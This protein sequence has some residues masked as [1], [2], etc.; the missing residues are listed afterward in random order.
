MEI[1]LEYLKHEELQEYKSMLDDV[2]GESNSL[3]YFQTYY[4]ENHPNVKVIVAKKGNEIIGTIT[5]TLINTFTSPLD[6][7]IEFSNFATSLS[8]R[9]TNAATRLMNFVFDYAKE[10]GYHSIAV[11]CLADA[12]RAHRFYEKMG[13]EKLD[14]VRFIAKKN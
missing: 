4:K 3:E 8:A 11:N 14:H 10:H 9:G 5:F 13:F 12:D 1:T 7:K 2:L 6:P